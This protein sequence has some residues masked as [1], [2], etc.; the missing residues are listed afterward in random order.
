MAIPYCVGK[1]M[2]RKIFTTTDFILKASTNSNSDFI[3]AVG[4]KKP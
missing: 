1:I 2:W 3:R 4:N